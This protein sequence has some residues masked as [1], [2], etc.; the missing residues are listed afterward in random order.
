MN[1]CKLFRKELNSCITTNTVVLWRIPVLVLCLLACT[2]ALFSSLWIWFQFCLR[3]YTMMLPAQI[4]L[5]LLWKLVSLQKNIK[6]QQNPTIT[7]TL[8]NYSLIL[9][10]KECSK[11]W[12]DFIL[13]CKLTGVF[14]HSENVGLCI[15]CYMFFSA[16]SFNC[17]VS[18]SSGNP[19]GKYCLD[20]V[21]GSFS[22]VHI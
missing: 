18:L 22:C 16:V 7:E 13:R 8:K 19:Q 3:K 12:M 20:I 15:L 2:F 4:E 5:H 9:N 11:M 21:C 1:L 14:S 17:L 10:S 6:Q